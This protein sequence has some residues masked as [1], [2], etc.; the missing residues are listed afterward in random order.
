METHR[1]AW[2]KAQHLVSGKRL[3]ESK[4]FQ[5]LNQTRQTKDIN[6]QNL[7]VSLHQKRIRRGKTEAVRESNN[8]SRIRDLNLERN[9]LHF[10]RTHIQT[11]GFIPKLGKKKLS[12]IYQK[13]SSDLSMVQNSTR[14]KENQNVAFILKVFIRMTFIR[15]K[16]EFRTLLEL[17]NSRVGTISLHCRRYTK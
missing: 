13:I 14:A 17:S 16:R 7:P 4:R 9:A 8:D 12:L 2:E 6:L 10:K 5:L 11:K 1:L 3:L 15:I